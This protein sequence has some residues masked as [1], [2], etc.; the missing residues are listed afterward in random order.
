VLTLAY[1]ALTNLGTAW[2][3]GALSEP[4]PV[5]VGGLAF[6]AWHVAANVV[7]FAVAAPAL[8]AAWRRHEAVRS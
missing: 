1:D 8:L 3:M 5:L 2:A 4:W 6:G 7:L